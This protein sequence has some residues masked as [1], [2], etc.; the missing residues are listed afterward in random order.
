MITPR[1]LKGFR[2][3]LPEAMIPRERL[4]ETARTVYRSFGYAPIDTPALEYLEVLN[5]KGGEESDR[6]LYQFVDHG[7]RHVG[8]RFDLTVPLARFAAQHIHELGTPFKRY[9]IA[10]VWRGE[11]P[12]RGRYREF[13]QCDFDTIGV[14]SAAADIETAVVIHS[15]LRAIGLE[16]F[17]I[18]VNHRQVLNG[19]LDS[20]GLA[21]QSQHVLRAIDKLAK[22]GVEKVVE[23]MGAPQA[24]PSNKPATC[25]P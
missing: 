11:S 23:E 13:M 6:Q 2:D 8:M 9:H 16:R 19:L 24:P 10:T 17:T 22:I 15:L 1:T 25:W 20:L 21:D 12:Q 4:M 7:D 18:R 14:E 3:Y 5:G